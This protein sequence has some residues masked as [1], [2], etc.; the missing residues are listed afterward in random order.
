MTI[1]KEKFLTYESVRED[2][3]T[4]MFDIKMVI[5]LA[6]ECYNVELTRDEVQ[7]IMK[8]YSKYKEEYFK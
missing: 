3:Q 8:N 5:N 4:N 7:D 2:G 1:S 6:D